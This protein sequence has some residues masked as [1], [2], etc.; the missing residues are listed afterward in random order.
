MKAFDASSRVESAEAIDAAA[1]DWLARRYGGFS[2]DESAA[3]A[4]WLAADP[5]HESAIVD[6]EKAWRV[7]SSP[8]AAGQGVI[9]RE[10]HRVRERRRVRQRRRRATATALG[11]A[12]AALLIFALLPPHG[13][14]PG[15]ASSV[16]IVQRPDIRS[17]P[18]GSTVQLN[19]GSAIAPAFTAEK[20]VVQLISGEALFIV[21]KDAARPFVV[22]AGG[23]EVKA[24]GTAFS[25]RYHPKQVDVLVTEGTVSIERPVAA[26]VAP[27]T[28]GG[29][30]IVSNERV[31]LPAGHRTVVPLVAMIAPAVARVTP[32]EI[33][34]ALAWRERRIEFT[35]TPLSEAVELFNRQNDLQLVVTDTR[36]GDFEISG[37]FWADDPDG[38]V[39]LLESAF[40]MTTD[41][42]GHTVVIRIK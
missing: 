24:V 40:E 19:A 37:I 6:L 4:A 41:R 27:R 35:R 2:A 23:V 9:A 20:R 38:F 18:D 7:V 5:R 15:P 3:F 11:L 25:V 13:S 21:A 16:R 1:A 31:L 32:A 42:T 36:T 28:S 10:R 8:G 29:A 12:A 33:A 30:D 17:L 34:A 26:T 14:D 22:S 39:R